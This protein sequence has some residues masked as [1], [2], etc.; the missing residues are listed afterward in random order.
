MA[1]K[2]RTLAEVIEHQDELAERFERL[3]PCRICGKE[4]KVQIQKNTGYCSAKHQEIGDLLAR[5]RELQN[6]EGLTAE[7]DK[8]ISREWGKAW[9]AYIKACKRAGI[10]PESSENPRLGDW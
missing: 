8:I 3:E 10:E 7:D 9:R 5:F 2:N 6:A 4:V 1:K